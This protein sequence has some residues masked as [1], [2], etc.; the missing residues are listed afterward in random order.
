MKR[1]IITLLII[2]PV[3]LYAIM[4]LNTNSVVND[5]K[6]IMLGNVEESITEN[7]P[8]SRYNFS[9]VLSNAEVKAKITRLF[10]AHN[11]S[12]GYMWVKYSYDTVKNDNDLMP[13]S[14]NV[15]SRWKIHKE[16]GKWEVVEIIEDP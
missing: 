2:I 6:N 5:V 16:N 15:T 8:L 13:G 9:N 4:L 10:V 1:N 3:L 7:T 11:F 14:W 12:D